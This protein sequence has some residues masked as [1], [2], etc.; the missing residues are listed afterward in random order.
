MKR[1]NWNTRE[2][3]RETERFNTE[4][5]LANFVL[6]AQRHKISSLPHGD[7]ANNFF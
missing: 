1:E 3:R 6:L 4:E 5:A 2:K 7:T